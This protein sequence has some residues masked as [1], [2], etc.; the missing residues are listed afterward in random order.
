MNILFG[1]V[2]RVVLDNPVHF[3]YVQSPSGYVCTAED[4]ML[5]LTKLKKCRSSFLLFLATLVEEG[6]R[7]ERSRK[8]RVEKGEGEGGGGEK[9]EV[10]RERWGHKRITTNPRTK[11]Q[12][13]N[14]TTC[15]CIILCK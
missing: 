6:D 10:E 2:R 7:T 9:D 4:A 12:T 15:T 3:W 14:G 5:S 8:E 1:V 11:Q 13:I